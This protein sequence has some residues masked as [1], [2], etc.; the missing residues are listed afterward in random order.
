MSAGN[1]RIRKRL[2]FHGVVQGVGFRW[3]ARAAADSA[4]VTGWV[5]NNF[6][7]S[8]TMELQGSEAQID[9]VVQT[10]ERARY[11]RIEALEA[12]RIPVDPEERRFE[13]RDD[14]W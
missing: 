4:G 14:L 7:G 12:R 13:V 1:E 8:V 9:R 10:L 6:D 2:V 3:R 5:R 11:I